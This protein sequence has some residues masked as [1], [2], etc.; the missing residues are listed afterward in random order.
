MGGLMHK[1]LAISGPIA[2]GKSSVIKELECRFRAHRVSTRSFIQSI[3]GSKAERTSLQAAGEQLDQSTG[4]KWISDS[5]KKLERSFGSNAIV[6]VDSVRIE[7]QVEHL[8]QAFGNRI[9]HVHLS[10]SDEV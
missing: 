5:L 8:R 9:V 6:I 10:A 1:I 2:V 3:L 7:K 4:G